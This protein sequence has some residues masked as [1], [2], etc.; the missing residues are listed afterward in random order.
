[1]WIDQYGYIV[2]FITLLIEL[3]AAGI[4]T[5][6]LMSYAGF[7]VYQG[8]LGY[9]PAILAAWIGSALGISVAYFIGWRLG[10]PFF[11]KYGPKVH[12]GPERLDKFSNWFSKYGAGLIVVAY[13]IPGIRHITGYFSG[14]TRFSFAKFATFAYIG[15]FLWTATF[16]SLG[17]ALGT[18]WETLH[19][20]TTKYVAIGAIAI[21]VIIVGLY[22]YKRFGQRIVHHLKVIRMHSPLR[23]KL[24]IVGTGIG[25][26]VLFIFMVGV[27]QDYLA[28]ESSE[29]DTIVTLVVQSTFGVQATPFMRVATYLSSPVL[30]IPVAL[31]TLWWAW[32]RDQNRM[33][34]IVFFATVIVGGVLLESILQ[35]VFGRIGPSTS[36]IVNSLAS[37]FP[38][39]RSVVSLTVW[40][41][42]SYLLIRH[43]TR[44]MVPFLVIPSLLLIVLILSI[45]HLYFG[46]QSA[47]DIVA[48]YV[49]AGVWLSINIMFLD[50]LRELRRSGSHRERLL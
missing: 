9:I 27:I 5:E 34:E 30:L 11:H 38:G 3:I 32:R 21:G 12:L 14:I 8:R 48:G 24:W 20:A 23:A 43:A 37:A 16:V 49:F 7:M 18:Q 15:A 31:F 13:F 2:L 4:P 29:L 50:I 22:I 39:E 45:S 40:G 1:M 42:F 36:D 35:A 10:A 44:L 17:R 25:F 28:N 47:S 19:G 41:Y 26:V 33:L 6:I 46:V